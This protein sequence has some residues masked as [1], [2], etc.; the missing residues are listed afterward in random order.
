MSKR[1]VLSIAVLLLFSCGGTSSDLSLNVTWAFETGDCASNAITTVRVTWGPAGGALTDVDFPCTAGGG[2]LGELSASAGTYTIRAVGLD[3]GGVTRVTHLGTS[4][5]VSSSS[6]TGG[7]PIALTLR[8]KSADVVVTW[9]L[10]ATGC[11]S[12][13]VLPYHVALYRPPAQP[14]GALTMKVKEEQETCS[15]RTV[16]LTS[17]APGS[18]VVEIDSRAVQPAIRGTKDITV[19]AGQDAMVA[20]QL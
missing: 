9:T 2:K 7:E 19:V 13:V 6:G 18:Y 5:T 20:F 10:G 12:P 15:A 11:P 14:G 1:P 4:L 17:I 8:P 3:A 16:T